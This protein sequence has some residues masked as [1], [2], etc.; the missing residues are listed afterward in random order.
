MKKYADLNAVTW[1]AWFVNRGSTTHAFYLQNGPLAPATDRRFGR[2]VGHASSENGI[3]WTAHK[4]VLAPLFDEENPADFH[5]KFTGCAVNRDDVCYLF[6]TMR[7]RERASQRIGVAVSTDWEHFEP[8]AGNPVV[9]NSSAPIPVSGGG[10]G[11]LIG[12]ENLAAY[13]WNIVD[14]RDFIVVPE[15]EGYVGYW[16]AAAD[17]GR[18]CPVG[19]IAMARSRDL[20]HW[21]D[22]RIVYT[23]DHHGVLEVPDVFYMDGKWVLCCLSGMHYSGRA[24]TSDPYASNA[25][26]VAY[27]DTCEGPFIEPADDNILIAGPVQSGFTCRSVLRRGERY[28]YYID[29]AVPKNNLSLPKELHMQ[30][31]RLRAT[32]CRA[33]DE[34]LSPLP[35]MPWIAEKNSFA[36]RTFGGEHTLQDGTLT[37]TTFARD[38][39]AISAALPP[40]VAQEG[41]AVL[42]ADVRV[43]GE[44]GGLFLRTAGC[45]YLVLLEPAQQRVALWRLYSFEQIAARRCLIREGEDYRVRCVV[46]D[47]VIELYLN[48]VLLLQC[49]LPTTP[50]THLGFAADR[51]T[52]QASNISLMSLN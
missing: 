20:L 12:Y 6:Y 13:D 37:L 44:G 46:V 29:R 36:W 52:L 34:R 14:C 24:V 16:A 15:G 42:C 50:L 2:A 40:E 3:D 48:D 1:D 38:Y 4:S 19:V 11:T 7:D 22:Q 30:Q 33:L 35:E 25:T 17:L 51:G 32:W 9:V 28:L 18:K 5:S 8:Y 23:V 47:G 10:M 41:S 31:G 45:P 43:T 39:H 27:A 49:G 21:E 26:I